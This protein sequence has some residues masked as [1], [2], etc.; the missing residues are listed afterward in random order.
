MKSPRSLHVAYILTNGTIL[1][2]AN[3][4]MFMIV[5]KNNQHA[6]AQRMAKID[7][8]FMW[9]IQKDPAILGLWSQTKCFLEIS[10]ILVMIHLT[11]SL[12]VFLKRLI[13]SIVSQQMEFLAWETIM[14][15]ESKTSRLFS[16][17]CIINRKS[18]LQIFHFVQD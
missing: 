18:F 3:Q 14:D 1:M 16:L 11:T 17:R 12:D 4:D 9:D 13:F 8:S 7:A 5:K 6:S 10:G 15:Q 2:R